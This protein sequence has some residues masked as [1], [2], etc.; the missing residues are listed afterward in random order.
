M[1]LLRIGMLAGLVAVAACVPRR[2]PPPPPP[3]QPAPVQQ[4]APLPPPVAN[5]DWRD[6][7][8]TPGNWVY[9]GE[10]G[11]STALFGTPGAPAFAVQCDRARRQVTLTRPGNATGNVMTIRTSF[12]ARNFPLTAQPG[13]AATSLSPSDRFL[14]T[15]AFSRGRFMVEVPG[16]A[17][18]IIP[19]WPEPA[20]VV[21]DC[22]G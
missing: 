4:P 5:E 18:L 11:G 6:R 21:E 15:I 10:G 8:L 13:H 7:P 16:T 2:E 22:R 20:R 3:Q 19:A 17:P 1:R 9:R 12:G 14:D